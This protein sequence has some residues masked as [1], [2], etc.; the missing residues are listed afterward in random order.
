MEKKEKVTFS[1][2]EQNEIKY[3]HDS[4]KIPLKDT[5]NMYQYFN[6]NLNKCLKYY[7]EEIS[8]I[9]IISSQL[10]IDLED[11]K[12]MYYDNNKDVVL[13]IAK[14]LEEIGE[15]KE[16]KKIPVTIPVF[17]HENKN[18]EKIFEQGKDLIVDKN[19]G[20][21]YDLTNN[22]KYVGNIDTIKNKNNIFNNLRNIAN[23]KDNIMNNY[24]KM[25]KKGRYKQ[26]FN[27]EK[28]LLEKEVE[29]KIN[30]YNSDIEFRKKKKS[31][32][33]INLDQYKKTLMEKT[34]DELYSKYKHTV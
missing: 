6:K 31:E 13:S 25:Q 29:G 24:L 27:E 30:I 22:Y 15:K 2:K 7:H 9:T 5:E 12:V 8:N 28:K 21:V 14:Y 32:G 16:K 20:S 19:D 4:L 26:S 10:G 1:S 3:L 33:I 34:I 17:N 18:T 23:D 11:A